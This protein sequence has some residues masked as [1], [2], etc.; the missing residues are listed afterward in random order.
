MVGGAGVEVASAVVYALPGLHDRVRTSLAS[1]PGVEIHAETPDG[2]FI[3]TVEGTAT[4]S[5]G[6]ILIGI[7]NLQGVLAAA[8]V[9]H[10]DNR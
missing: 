10:Y 3:V 2:R 5:A 8:M 7:H 1:L 6:D 9:S 4:A